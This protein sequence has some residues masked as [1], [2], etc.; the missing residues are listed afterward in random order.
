M[1]PGRRGSVPWYC[2]NSTRPHWRLEDDVVPS[3]VNRESTAPATH[4][5]VD[6]VTAK[7]VLVFFTA[8]VVNSSQMIASTRRQ[9]TRQPL[10][11]CY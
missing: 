1:R 11:L 10:V 9:N 7:C 2:Q 5:V 6:F 4:L 8:V 3:A